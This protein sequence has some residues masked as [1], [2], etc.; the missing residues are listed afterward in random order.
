L[1]NFLQRLASGII[2]LVILIGSLLLGKFTFG[3]VFLLIAMLALSEYYS[4]AEIYGKSIPAILG[5]I[6]GA[7]VF[8]LAF[9]VFSNIIDI[10]Y[11]A[12]AA[13]L[14][15]LL[16]IPA[17]YTPRPDFLNEYAKIFLA[18]LYVVFPLSAANY[19]VFPACAGGAYT[20]HIVLGILILVWINDTAAYLT[21]TAFGRHKLI[22]HISPKKSWEGLIGGTLLTLG[23]SFLMN[24]I[25]GDM[26]TIQN[27][28]VLA[29]IV[30]IFGVYGDLTESLI[31]R[32]AG[33]KDSGNIMPG[34][35]GILDRIDSILFVMPVAAAYLAMAGL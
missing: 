33:K 13:V 24:R 27:W 14:P 35:G 21:G 17:L 11:L 1:R 16:L 20:Y 15:V 9:L 19:L 26:L 18:L 22:P 2:Y 6:S 34:H 29:V 4:L 32:N 7:V 28:L 12:L 8:T 23:A 25:M 10:Q 3:A 5:L 30:S 31:K